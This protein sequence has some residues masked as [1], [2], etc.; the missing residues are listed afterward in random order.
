MRRL[1]KSILPLVLFLGLVAPAAAEAPYPNRPVKLIVPWIAGSGIDVQVRQF[2]DQLGRSLQTPVVVENR[3]GA[4]S[5]IGYEA[6]ARS[7][8]DGYTLFA[9]TNANFIHQ[10]MRPASK[11]DPVRDMEP[12]T[13]MFWMPSVLVVGAASP[14]KDVPGLLAWARAKPGSLNYGSGGVGAASH[15]LASMI[16]NKNGLSVTHVPMQ[17]LTANLGPMLTRGDI[18]FAL[19][20]TGVASAQIQQGV[21]RPLAITSSQ[22]MARWPDVPTLAEVFKEDIFMADSWTGLFTPKGTPREIVQRIHEAAVQAVASAQHTNSA[23]FFLTLPESSKSP[24][25]FDKFFR[26]EAVK[27]KE[28]VRES[29]ITAD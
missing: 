19:P 25:D 24:G 29:G 27:W 7:T 11:I 6:A 12:V 10:Y 2:A 3:S 5:Q 22:R 28:I 1:A 9:G 18:H 4:G 21:V 13:M 20:V 16:A 23:E 17:S 14:A 8:A 26:A 15:L